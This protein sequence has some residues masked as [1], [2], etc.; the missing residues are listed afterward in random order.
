MQFRPCKGVYCR[1]LNLYVN[2]LWQF[3]ADEKSRSAILP[4]PPSLP[5]LPS[6]EL[7]LV[8]DN[9]EPP[10]A[11]EPELPEVITVPYDSGRSGQLGE[12]SVAGVSVWQLPDAP[13]GSQPDQSWLAVG[14]G[15]PGEIYISGHDHLSNSMLYRLFQHDQ[16]LRWVGD[17]R[18]GS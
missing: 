14:S 7:S 11:E 10:I 16:T 15:A 2:R 18:T 4:T 5:N 13:G 1:L 12:V 17:A 6:T 9:P 8:P 3:A